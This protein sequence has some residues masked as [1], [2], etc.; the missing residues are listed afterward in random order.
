MPLEFPNSGTN[1]SHLNL[2]QNSFKQN[3]ISYFFGQMIKSLKIPMRTASCGL[4]NGPS[5]LL[6]VLH[7]KACISDSMGTHH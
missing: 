2:S 7:F 1:K 3:L 4:N 6:L 5:D